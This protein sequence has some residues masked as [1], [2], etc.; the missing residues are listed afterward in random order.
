MGNDQLCCRS[1]Q[2]LE[3]DNA[4]EVKIRESL[5]FALSNIKNLQDINEIAS[6][7]FESELLDINSTP[8]EWITKPRY[9]EFIDKIFKISLLE[10]NKIKI[11]DLF[12]NYGEVDLSAKTYRDK[13][14]LVLY[15]WII[16]LLPQ[17]TNSEMQKK[18]YE[19][20]KIILKAEKIL[21]YKTLKNYIQTILELCLMD[22]T[23]NF[24]CDKKEEQMNLTYS[25]YNVKN[26]ND[27][28][29]YI[30]EKIKKNLLA[31]AMDKRSEVSINNEY[32]N[33]YQLNQ[34]LRENYMLL[35]ALELRNNFYSR[36]ER[37]D[38]Q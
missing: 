12:P 10:K 26:M 8:L 19:I 20:K 6:K 11:E 28:L 14:N 29:N 38:A 31:T 24:P 36:Y 35:N 23:I 3:V 16:L 2:V 18:I 4:Q 7:I 17:G 32:I 34:I 33:D 30:C 13:F 21:T 37:Y 15:A 1:E 9:S 27:Y 22:L 25:M 5:L